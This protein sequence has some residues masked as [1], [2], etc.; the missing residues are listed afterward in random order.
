MQKVLTNELWRAVRAQARNALRR[1]AAIAYVT[2]DL[3][4]FRKGDVLVVDASPYAI[5]NGETNAK[6]LRSLHKRGVNLYDCSRLHAKV[7]L[8]ADVAV[9]GSGNMSKSSL[10]GLVE[11]GVM[12]DHVST[13]AGVAS[14]IEQ[15][16]RLSTKL[17]EKQIAAL[18][19]I[20][21]VR[22]DGRRFGR[23][24]LQRPKIARLGIRTWLVGVREIVRDLPSVD[25]RLVDQGFE[26]VRRKMGNP[27]E[28]PEW[29]R[30]VA[31]SRFAR[32]SREGDSLIRIWHR[33]N[34]KRSSTVAHA[35]PVLLKKTT[36]K[37][38]WYF[39]PETVGP[40]REI[41]LERFKRMLREIGYTRKI[42]EYGAQF[43]EP[44]V[45]DAIARK[46]R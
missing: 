37:R 26:T 30:W 25:Q 15:L 8:L 23:R 1:K 35:S 45:T 11:A 20:R 7:L 38:T 24:K 33:K 43:L 6:L 2:E 28:D 36:Q 40:R 39:L 18:C 46:W 22:P 16:Q 32:E 13:V 4:R 34:G 31:K 27:E 41:P 21:V 14:F 17:S 12:T 42:H 10:N 44:E 29:V 19:R 5:R 9:I 3:I